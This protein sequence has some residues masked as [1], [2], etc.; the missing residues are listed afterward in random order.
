MS[1][2]RA[3][4]SRSR[5]RRWAAPPSPWMRHRSAEELLDALSQVSGKPEEFP[6][7]PPGLRAVQLPDTHVKS[8]FMDILGRPPRVITCEC[9]RSQEPNMA[10]ALLFINGELI[11]RKATADGG[12]VD[13][14]VKAGRTDSE[15]VDT[16]YWT[17]LSRPP[18]LSERASDLQAVKAAIAES[19][20]P[21]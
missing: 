17:A 8:D 20:R 19:G 5:R 12:I 6:G 13:R 15:I 21:Q 9:E 1:F 18:S 10:Q 2:S 11:N 14:L 7:M 16:L 4:A 3:W